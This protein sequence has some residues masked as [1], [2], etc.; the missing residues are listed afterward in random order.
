[1]KLYKCK[2]QSYIKIVHDSSENIYFF[3]HLD[4]MYS[5][6]KAKDGR[7]LHIAAYTDV[8]IVTRPNNWDKEK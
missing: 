8:E 3:D 4:G 7:L 1:M 6:C 5:Y 2:R